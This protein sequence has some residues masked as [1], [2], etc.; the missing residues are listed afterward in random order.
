MIKMIHQCQVQMITQ[1]QSEYN[2]WHKLCGIQLKDKLHINVDKRKKTFEDV[3]STA[4]LKISRDGI[5]DII[6]TPPNFKINPTITQEAKSRM[7]SAIDAW[8][9][10]HLSQCKKLPPI[11]KKYWRIADNWWNR[12]KGKYFGDLFFQPIL[13]H[14]L[15]RYCKKILVRKGIR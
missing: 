1:D 2:R 14:S 11:F 15:H 8:G 9:G 3:V 12:Q 4:A 6:P 7:C 5:L 13:H 10:V